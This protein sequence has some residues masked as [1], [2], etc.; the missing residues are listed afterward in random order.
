MPRDLMADQEMLRTVAELAGRRDTARAAALAEQALSGG[1]EHPLLLNVLATRLE[2]EGKLEEARQLLERAVRMAPDDVSARNALALCLQRLDRPGEALY[3]VD[4]LLREH[5]ELAFVHAS[6]GNALI[7]LGALKKARTSLLRALELDP[8]NLAAEASLA[9]IATHLGEHDEA[10]VRARKVLSRVPGFPDS[11]L[12]L[13]AAELAGGSI[14]NAQMLVCQLLAEGRAGPAERAR[15]NGLLGD[16][17]DA[18]GRYME[19][20][21]AYA[22][23]NEGLRELHRRFLHETSMVSY[24]EALITALQRE[25]PAK[26]ATPPAASALPG[27]ASTH[28]FLVGFPC[29]GTSLLGLAIEGHPRVVTLAEHE[30]L[31]AGVLRYMREPLDFGPLLHA[32]EGELRSLRERYW[33]EVREAGVVPDG[34]VFVD[35]HPL[36]SLKL[37]LIARLFPEAKILF[38]HRDPRDVILSCFRRRFSLNPLTYQLLTLAGGAAFYDATMHFTDRA[39]ALLRLDWQS[40]RCEDLVE[41]LDREL[42]RICAFIGLEWVPGLTDI[43]TRLAGSPDGAHV[44]HWQHY[45]PVLEPILPTLDPWVQRLGYGA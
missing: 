10:R 32:D 41:D 17:L 24:L 37:P 34:K 35:R 13:A 30:L 40:V 33:Q 38:A 43:R 29:S 25:D 26:W 27:A 22:A 6:K 20:F 28:V 3:H 31:K 8:E 39:R 42:R 45:R 12:S 23:C 5:P 21:G 2:L 16:V 1:F 7:A 36:H 9:S 44:G 15:A 19:A 11:I 18:G 14:D 4:K